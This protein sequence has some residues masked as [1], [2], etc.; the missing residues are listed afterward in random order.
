MRG[1][2]V[3]QSVA[4]G[5]VVGEVGYEIGDLV[6]DDAQFPQP[7]A[8][9]GR[10]CGECRHMVSFAGMKLCVGEAVVNGADEVGLVNCCDE[11][12]EIFEE[13]G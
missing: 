10:K 6:P 3:E 8:W 7:E 9:E 11:A 1:F 5:V 4:D 2:G 13:A 12:C